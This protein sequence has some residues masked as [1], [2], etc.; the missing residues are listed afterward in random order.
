MHDFFEQA[1]EVDMDWGHITLA[2]CGYLK[3][4]AKCFWYMM[5]RKWDNNGVPCLPSIRDLPV[6]VMKVP[7]KNGSMVPIPLRDV[8]MDE[9]TLRVY[10][11]AYPAGNFGFHVT[12]KMNE[13]HLWG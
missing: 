13:T 12:T 11:Y 5:A 9:N 1:Q 2:T 6:L 8:T 4:T 7:Q 10:K 3:T